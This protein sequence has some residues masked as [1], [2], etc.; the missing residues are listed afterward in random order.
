MM[1]LAASYIAK[2]LNKYHWISYLGLAVIVYVAV[3]MLYHGIVEVLP[4]ITG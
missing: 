4:Y 3:T 1:G 2:L